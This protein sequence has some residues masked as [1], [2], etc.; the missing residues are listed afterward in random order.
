MA[1]VSNHTIYISLNNQRCLT[2]P[3]LIKVNPDEY[4][5]GYRYYPFMVNLDRCDEI[6]NTSDDPSGRVCVE[7]KIEDINLKCF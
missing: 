6:C 1:N 5:Q 7:N 3:I 4:N 2:R